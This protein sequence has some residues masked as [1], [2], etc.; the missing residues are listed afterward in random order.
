MTMV[1]TLISVDEY[2]HTSYDPDC[3]Y[4]DGEV[5]ERNMAERDHNE[6]QGELYAFFHSC[7]R[8]WNA[9]PF[10]E[11]RIQVA[12]TRFRV[13]DICICLERPNEQVFHTPPFICIEI[14]SP[15]D[16]IERI[17]DRIDDYLKFSVPYVWVI[18]PR[19][20]RAWV[21][22]QDSIY[23]AKDGV[24]RTENPAFTVPLAEIFAA[25][26]AQAPQ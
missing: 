7:R 3:D 14:L 23:E 18:N 2:L 19:S 12:S 4:V 16:R 24:L 13:P 8:T 15:E 6:L 1:G 22:T 17:Q 20:R 21:Y 5:L 10:L 11:Q 26:D 9:Y 25:L